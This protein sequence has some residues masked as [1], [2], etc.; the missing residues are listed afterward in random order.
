VSAGDLVKVPEVVDK[1]TGT[2]DVI[3]PAASSIKA[4]PMI[5]K[6]RRAWA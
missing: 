3:E 6:A 1:N 2:D 4:V 5:Y